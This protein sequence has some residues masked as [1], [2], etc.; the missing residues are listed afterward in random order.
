M[1]DVGIHLGA[2]LVLELFNAVD[3][4]TNAFLILFSRQPDIYHSIILPDVSCSNICLCYF[5]FYFSIIIL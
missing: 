5:S 4:S 2:V 1:D 3:S